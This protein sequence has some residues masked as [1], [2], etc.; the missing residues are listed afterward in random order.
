MKKNINMII[1]LS[2][3]VLI[4]IASANIAVSQEGQGAIKS[5]KD[6]ASGIGQIFKKNSTR[7]RTGRETI[8]KMLINKKFECAEKIFNE[9]WQKGQNRIHIYD[10]QEVVKY[11][12]QLSD[13]ENKFEENITHIMPQLRRNKLSF[14]SEFIN[15]L[16]DYGKRMHKQIAEKNNRIQAERNKTDE[17]EYR[18]RLEN[19]RIQQEEIRKEKAQKQY[20]REERERIRKEEIDR[21][22]AA[23]KL[24]AKK[25]EQE[26]EQKRDR[27]KLALTKQVE[28]LDSDFKDIGFKGYGRF[29]IMALLY[30][31]Q[32]GEKSLSEQVNFVFGC[33]SLKRQSCM[34]YYPKA[35]ITQVLDNGNLYSYN[36]MI[37]DEF[38]TFTFFVKK[39]SGKMYF[40][41]QGLEIA[42]YAFKG[43]VQY[44]TVM[45]AIK[46]VPMFE[47]V[48]YNN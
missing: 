42:F 38:L 41:G 37:G 4:T 2:I 31:L 6:L 20:E 19:Q 44:T 35:K 29:Q 47:P 24:D 39:M 30:K 17:E 8:E 27:E 40:D 21:K 1:R 10:F 43:T 3:L 23:R 45:G 34:T 46:T 28:K 5:Y 48:P 16:N 9:S 12:K 26:R 13:I 36:E 25:R 32:T 11:L 18:A 7:A 14:S 22:D 15:Y 33:P